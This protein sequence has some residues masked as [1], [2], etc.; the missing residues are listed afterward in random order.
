MK[1]LYVLFH[2]NDAILFNN[3]RPSKM[4]KGDIVIEN[5]DL[6]YVTGLS[7]HYWKLVDGRI[8]PMNAA[9]RALKHSTHAKHYKTFK[10][11]AW[12]RILE[13]VLLEIFVFAMGAI[14]IYLLIR[15]GIIK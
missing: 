11:V 2:N 1:K 5:P 14:T 7:P 3:T 10:G 6:Q 15:K 9:E 13:R 12:G 8:F 4:A